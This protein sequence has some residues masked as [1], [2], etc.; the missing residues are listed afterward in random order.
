MIEFECEVILEEGIKLQHYDRML[1]RFNQW[2]Q[3]KR[4]IKITSLLEG[5]RILYNIYDIKGNG[6]IGITTDQKLYSVV[7]GSIRNKMFDIHSMSFIINGD[8]IDELK[9]IIKP[10]DNHRGESLSE[11]IKSGITPIIHQLLEN[12]SISYFYVN[13]NYD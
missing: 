2:T 9:I 5:K 13:E 6:I 8:N 3:F 12:D 1:S 4:D 10:L 11:I 7:S